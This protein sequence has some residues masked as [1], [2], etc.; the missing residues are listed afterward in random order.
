MA[1]PLS[2]LTTELHHART[3]CVQWSV[4][5][6]LLVSMEIL[7][8]KINGSCISSFAKSTWELEK[9]KNI[10]FVKNPKENNIN[11][12]NKEENPKQ[13][14]KQ[15]QQQKHEASIKTVKLLHHLLTTKHFTPRHIELKLKSRRKKAI[16]YT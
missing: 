9:S 2:L 8:P 15:Q 6:S 14:G 11:K 16:H 13:K 4:W 12:I 7:Q 5:K 1:S 10:P 3:S